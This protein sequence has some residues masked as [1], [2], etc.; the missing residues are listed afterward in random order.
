MAFRKRHHLAF[1]FVIYQGPGH[2]VR[3]KVITVRGPM[4]FKDHWLL[5]IV[6]V[7]NGLGAFPKNR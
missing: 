4:I 5:F 1:G 2:F 7:E 3:F 6:K